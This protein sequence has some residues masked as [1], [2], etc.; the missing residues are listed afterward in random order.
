M[1]SRLCDWSQ[2]YAK[3]QQMAM[4]NGSLIQKPNSISTLALV[5]MLV[6]HETGHLMQA[7]NTLSSLFYSYYLMQQKIYCE[8]LNLFIT[9]VP[10]NKLCT[11]S[12]VQLLKNLYQYKYI[13]GKNS[14]SFIWSCFFEWRKNALQKFENYWLIKCSLVWFANG[15]YYVK[16]SK[17]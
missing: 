2:K 5:C 10:Q 12:K 4:I 8:V 11:C 3:H 7:W 1:I 16:V 9:W 15:V 14:C 6:F 17:L 13:I